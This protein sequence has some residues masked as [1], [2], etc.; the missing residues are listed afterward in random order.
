MR[1]YLDNCAFNR[2]FDAQSQVRIHLEAEA[3]L[4]I[5]REVREGRLELAWSYILDYENLANPFG[6]RRDTI[7]AW[8]KY[9]VADANETHEIL[10]KAHALTRQGIKGKD[11]LHIACAIETKCDYFITTDDRLLKAMKHVQTIVGIDPT[12][13]V[14]EVEL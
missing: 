12:A 7:Q 5:Q 2:P 10:A 8:K 11:A 6:E 14:R 4:F 9:A 3:K 13:F 1:V